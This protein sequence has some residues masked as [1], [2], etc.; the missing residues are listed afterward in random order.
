MAEDIVATENILQ[1]DKEQKVENSIQQASSFGSI[2][3][4]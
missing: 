4:G 2:S 3:Q 1:V